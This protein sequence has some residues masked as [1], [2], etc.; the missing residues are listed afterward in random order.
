MPKRFTDWANEFKLMA[1]WVNL[2]HGQGVP[3]EREFAGVLK[4]V[5]RLQRKME[6]LAPP[7]ALR[8]R[9]PNTLAGIRRARPA[10]PRRYWQAIPPAVYREKLAGAWL[11]RCAGCTLGACV[12]FYSLEDMQH[13]AKATGMDYPPRA[14]WKAAAQP[15][16]LRYGKDATATYTAPG[17]TH[18]PVDDDLTYTL[19][20]LFILEDFGP[21]FTTE[22][23]GR[24][25]L[26]YLPYACTA[27]DVALRSLRRKVS[28]AKTAEIGNPYM[29]WIGGDIRADGWGYLAPGWPEKAA[30]L[31]WRESRISHRFSGIYGTMF[32]AAAISAA[33]AVSDTE[34]ALRVALTEIPRNCRTAQAVRWALG[35]KGRI[36]N[37]K[38]ARAAVDRKFPMLSPVHTDN[39]LCLSI[40]GLLIGRRDFG[41]VIG[42]T[43][44]MG[45]DNDCTAATAASIFGAAYGRRA[46]PDAWIKPFRNRIRTYMN[47][48]EWLTLSDTLKRFERGA[49][50]VFAAG[51]SHGQARS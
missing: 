8:E 24:A 17:L 23:V 48:R 36:R 29:E 35:Q 13:L 39:N 4:A 12:E 32:V 42:E 51:G 43:V 41:K 3:V 15:Y 10:G 9:E 37:W 31:A 5:A 7:A 25:W 11:G 19:L 21:D 38:A 2:R 14:Y 20:D 33:F 47:G 46:I 18:V 22:D 45:M 34:T 6:R 27:E 49:R 16:A 40:F 28:A 1:E 30:E 44:A 50:A 26:Q